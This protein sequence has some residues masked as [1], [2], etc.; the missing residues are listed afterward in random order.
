MTDKNATTGYDADTS[1]DVVHVGAVD[2]EKV[3]DDYLDKRQLKKGAAGWVLL[4]GLG[5][6]YV[7]SGDFAGWNFGLEQGG[8]GGLLIAT[9]LM[10]VMYTCMVL[11][12]AELSSAIPTAGGGYGFARRAMGP[13]GGF[14]TGTAILLEYA[15]APVAIAIFI[16][17]YV[18][19]LIGLDGPLVYAA[20]YVVFIGIHLV[21]VGEALKI[22][23]VIT[24]VAATALLVF[25]LGMI[26][27]FEFA[28]LTDIAVNESATGAN[29]FLP[30]G[31]VGI[32]AAIPFAMWFFLAIEGVPLAAEETKN[33]ARDMPRGIITAMMILLVF[34]GLILV[35]A[36][37]GS[38][39]E[40]M[41]NHGAPLVGA[42]QHAYGESALIVT[43]VNVVGLAGLIASFFSI[44][45]AYSRQVFALS[46]AGYLPKWLS[47]TGKHKVPTMALVVPGVIGFLLSLTGEGDLM[48]TIAVFG[49]TISYAMMMLSHI[50]LR[51]K[52]PQMERPYRTPGGVLTTGIAMVLAL[53]ALASTFVVSQEAAM[54]SAVFYAVMVAYFVFYSRHHLVAKAPEE[55]FAAIA[56]AEA[57][58]K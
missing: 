39:A 3:S 5:V 23:L 47:V 48:I 44:I 46:R 38:S 17:A 41:K 2:Y 52:D 30:E 31:Y 57:E 11:G 6:S 37:G 25:I 26:P 28:N 22:M 18:G 50:I 1:S 24:A 27:H 45:Y 29:P 10:A 40:L 8:F 56:S 15:I 49:A 9:L 32:W 20:F 53:G 55:E 16:G 43:F 36:P 51:K 21:G 4:A 14:L 13:L 33:P 34:G 54:W 12:V 7:I 58:L 42:L 19:E 35:L